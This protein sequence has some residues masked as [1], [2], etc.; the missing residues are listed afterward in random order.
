M[1]HASGTRPVVREHVFPPRLAL[2]RFAPFKGMGKS[3]CLTLAIALSHRCRK[4]QVLVTTKLGAK[5]SQRGNDQRCR[6][7]M[8]LHASLLEN[9]CIDLDPPRAWKRR[10]SRHGCSTPPLPCNPPFSAPAGAV[11]RFAYFGSGSRFV[12]SSGIPL[13]AAKPIGES[14]CVRAARIGIHRSPC[15][16]DG[17]GR[18]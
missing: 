9:A 4:E 18:R 2:P 15:N 14:V 17:C 16:H 11:A 12:S 1:R 7:G 5:R 6:R 13:G 8:Q 10:V 3:V